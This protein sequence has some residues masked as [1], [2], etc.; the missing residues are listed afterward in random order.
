MDIVVAN[1]SSSQQTERY[2]SQDESSSPDGS[3]FKSKI[4][5]D[6]IILPGSPNRTISNDDSFSTSHASPFKKPR[7][8]S[9]NAASGHGSAKPNDSTK[10][11]SSS[12]GEKTGSNCKGVD[13]EPRISGQELESIKSDVVLVS[14]I[15]EKF[16]QLFPRRNSTELFN[17]CIEDYSQNQ[18]LNRTIRFVVQNTNDSNHIEQLIIQYIG[19]ALDKV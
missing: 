11:S 2:S 16:K 18:K 4:K 14:F 7:S 12:L 3:P 19:R 10:T 15:K 5:V 9:Y 13:N 6:A 1:I 17:K 8:V